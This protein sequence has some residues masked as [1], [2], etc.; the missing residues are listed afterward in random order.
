[1]KLDADRVTIQS[2]TQFNGKLTIN[3]KID[4]FTQSIC[5]VK[6]KKMS[7]KKNYFFWTYILNS[8]KN[9]ASTFI[10]IPFVN[11]DMRYVTFVFISIL[12]F[13]Q[14]NTF[15]EKFMEVIHFF[16]AY[17]CSLT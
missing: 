13:Y 1:M 5:K 12:R 17:I 15:N 3:F 11:L 7:Y 9:N 4:H 16:P 8:T 2:K 6:R 14:F 10:C